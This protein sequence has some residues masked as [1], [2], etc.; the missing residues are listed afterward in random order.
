MSS[1]VLILAAGKG[2]RMKSAVPKVL[3]A[4]AGRPMIE[5]VLDTAAALSP[6]T[7]TV[8]VGHAGEQ[9]RQALG[10]RQGLGFLLQEPQLGTGHALLQAEPLFRGVQGTLV[11]L[12]GDVPLL[13]PA[14][15]EALAA[16]H[17]DSGA[18]A[19]VVTAVVE[20]PTGYGRIVREGGEVR[21]I[22]EHRDAT[23]EERSLRE[24]NSGIY[25]F[26][27][28][29]LFPALARI[30]SNNAQGEYY[31]TDL[32]ALYGSEGRRVSSF[33]V[34]DASEVLGINSRQEL[35]ATGR[36]VW[37]ARNDAL[38]AAGVTIE[39]PD[40]TFVGHGVSVGPDTVIRP[41]VVLEGTT[42]IGSRCVIYPGVRIEDSDLSDD[43]WVY[44]HC[45]ISGARIAQGA[46]VGPFA[47]MRPETVVDEGAHVGNFVELKKTHFGA[48]SKAMHLAYL[49][50]ATVGTRVNIGAGTIT[51]NYDGVRKSP[52]VIGDGAF[53]GSDSQLIAPVTVGSDA[54]VAAGSSITDDVPSGS[55]A[56]ARGRQLVKEGWV[57]R[58]RTAASGQQSADTRSKPSE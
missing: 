12:S 29:P 35:A 9:V 46:R 13:S 53:I 20:D 22:V 54:Y 49:G 31:L 7:C 23:A 2:T 47:R 58:K 45:V 6:A 43:V 21:R 3:H 24:I 27:L 38:M 30:G 15:L 56:I 32:V 11:L 34:P 36:R 37:R 17:T 26:D 52:T 1:H 14:T 48:G 19:T 18:A 55:L 10:G 40:T 4:V 50:D 5:F 25:A 42:R 39:D 28:E 57:Q 51:C 16:R 33:A 8:V 41:G 44:D